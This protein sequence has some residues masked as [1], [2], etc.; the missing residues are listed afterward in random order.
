MI[1]PEKDEAMHAFLK[2]FITYSQ[3]DL[4]LLYKWILLRGSQVVLPTFCI[5][6]CLQESKSIRF[7]VWHV[8]FFL[9]WFVML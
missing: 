8:M 7:C 9:E 4:A 6:H 3:S 1:C 5:L 2:R